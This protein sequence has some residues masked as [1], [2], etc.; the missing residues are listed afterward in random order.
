[1]LQPLHLHT[2]L[3]QRQHIGLSTKLKTFLNSS[4]GQ[5]EIKAHD[6]KNV[7]TFHVFKSS[8]GLNLTL[9]DGLDYF[10]PLTLHALG[11]SLVFDTGLDKVMIHPGKDGQLIA[12]LNSQLTIGQTDMEGS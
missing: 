2:K 8:Q 11:E 10:C 3:S 9:T 6:E 5:L 4:L 12:S 1:M 7:I